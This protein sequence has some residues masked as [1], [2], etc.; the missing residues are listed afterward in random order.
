MKKQPLSLKWGNIILYKS[1]IVP[2]RIKETKWEGCSDDT[3]YRAE[4]LKKNKEYIARVYVNEA[5]VG[6][7]KDR[8]S[9]FTALDNAVKSYMSH[10]EMK[11]ADAKRFFEYTR[12]TASPL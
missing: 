9:A 11:L 10:H 2:G 1:P 7:G 12:V 3:R 4:V 5:F 8:G 6:E